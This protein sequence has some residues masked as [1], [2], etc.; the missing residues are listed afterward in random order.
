[1]NLRLGGDAGRWIDV[2]G[3]ADIDPAKRPVID[4]AQSTC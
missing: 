4:L 2:L 1:V 3:S